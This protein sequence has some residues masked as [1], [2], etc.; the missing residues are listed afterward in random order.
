MQTGKT[1]IHHL[2][3]EL[4]SFDDVGQGYD[5]ALRPRKAGSRSRSA[6]TTGDYMTSFYTWTPSGFMVEYGW[7]GRSIDPETWTGRRAHRR[8]EPVGPRAILA[9]RGKARR[10]ARDAPTERRERRA[11][12]GAGDRRQLQAMAACARGGTA[13]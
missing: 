7:G 6:A 13:S 12:A 8:P 3:V 10:S 4:Y 5:L 1:A 2:M 11:P 9:P